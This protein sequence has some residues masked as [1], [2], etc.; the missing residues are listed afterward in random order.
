MIRVRLVK[1]LVKC[2]YKK[3]KTRQQK[4]KKYILIKIE[5]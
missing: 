1:R 2:Y 3:F 4:T 5:A